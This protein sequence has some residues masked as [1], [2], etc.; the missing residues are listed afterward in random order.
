VA[1]R[2]DLEQQLDLVD[3]VMMDRSITARPGPRKQRLAELGLPSN[4][5][6][7]TLM[8]LWRHRAIRE[9]YMKPQPKF[10]SI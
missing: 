8:N 7:P 5:D 6:I 1:T 9:R 3:Q 4:A 10:G 2:L